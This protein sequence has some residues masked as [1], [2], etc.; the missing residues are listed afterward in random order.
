MHGPI[1]I[2]LPMLLTPWGRVLLQKL[3]GFQLVKK[4]PVFN[5]TRRF[6]TAFTRAHH[7]SLSH[8][9]KSHL[10]LSNCTDFTVLFPA[11]IE[12]S[13][14]QFGTFFL[15]SVSAT[16]QPWPLILQRLSITLLQLLQT[17]N[18]GSDHR[19]YSI[20]QHKIE[21]K[22]GNDSVTILLRSFTFNYDKPR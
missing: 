4:F 9:T 22:L 1:N 10:S 2:R 21:N 13:G 6:I 11:A 15:L 20:R 16:H 14:H 19:K 8:G 7:L 18:S 5:G 12:V 17:L 3:T